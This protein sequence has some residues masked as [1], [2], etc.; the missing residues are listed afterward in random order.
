L[1]DFFFLKKK[2][3]WKKKRNLYVPF[4]FGSTYGLELKN[5]IETST[6]PTE[7]GKWDDMVGGREIEISGVASGL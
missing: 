4:I 6:D 7:G 2:E 3:K 5:V 1:N